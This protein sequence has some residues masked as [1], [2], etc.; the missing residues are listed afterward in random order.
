ME[1]LNEVTY[2]C[3]GHLDGMDRIDRSMEK[4]ACHGYEWIAQQQKCG[5][6]IKKNGDLIK[7]KDNSQQGICKSPVDS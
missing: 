7:T 2:A 5:T 6:E 4:N 1:I 3:S